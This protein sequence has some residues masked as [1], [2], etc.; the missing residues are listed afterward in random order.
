MKKPKGE[1][2]YKALVV[3]NPV[4][5]V[6]FF[7]F[8]AEGKIK[9]YLKSK[10]IDYTFYTTTGKDNEL[11]QFV[12]K[13]FDIILAIGGDGTV[14]EVAHWILRNNI[15]TSLGIIPMGT[16]N[17]YAM[18]LGIPLT[19]KRALK[20][21][22]KNKALTMDMGLVND[23]KYFMFAAGVGYDAE[24]MHVTSRKLKKIW[25]PWAY[26]ALA[27]KTSYDKKFIEG[28]LVTDTEQRKVKTRTI[29]AFNVRTAL[30]VNPFIPLEIHPG[31]LDVLIA[32]EIN[33]PNILRLT[34]RLTERNRHLDQPQVKLITSQKIEFKSDKDEI[35]EVDGDTWIG[36]Q[37]KI[38]II[39][40]AIK[41]VC[42]RK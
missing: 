28:E 12:K 42:D 19:L 29:V 21:A 5:G 7:R 39:P 35:F 8:G 32:D 25:G 15:N 36:K 37:I 20:F 31:T 18:G 34:K 38:E 23:E 33:V 1:R 13:Q 6:S 2:I 27:F 3:Y 26:F 10:K 11:D 40:E 4:S 16:S 17:I 9:R 14:R 30:N 24:F 41:I 22:I